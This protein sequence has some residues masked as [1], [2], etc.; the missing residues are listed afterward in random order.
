MESATNPRILITGA[1]GS[2]ARKLLVRCLARGIDPSS[3]ILVTRRPETLIGN[4]HAAVT[5][6]QGSFDDPENE[7]ARAF[8]GAEV[9]FM[10]STSRAGARIP[11]HQNA[12]NAAVKAGAQHILYTSFV[13]VDF[14]NPA[15]LVAREHKAT[16]AM[17]R[18]SSLAFTFLRDSM[19]LEAMSDAIL[20]S[21]LNAGCLR[22]NAGQGRI[23]LVSK[24]DCVE[25]AAAILANP[26]THLNKIYEITGPELLCFEEAAT[27]G[28]RHF[29]KPIPWCAISD[30][31]CFADFDAMGV[32]REPSDDLERNGVNGY[33]WNSSDMVSFGKGIRLGE[34]ETLSNDVFRLTGRQ[35]I[36][37]LGVL[38]R[39]ST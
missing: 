38:L 6:R 23:A 12:V 30:E 28:S 16:E 24:D 15:A 31:E 34:M 17:I 2:Y 33:H 18:Q 5:I 36:S 10:I 4:V 13:G 25:S 20:P 29:G 7:L 35:P 11:Q 19:Y 37:L 26:A 32:P 3:L 1:S 8:G 14:E 21:S 39:H 27:L 22:S 9:L